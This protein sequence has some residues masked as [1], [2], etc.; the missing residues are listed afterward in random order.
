MV[1][2]NLQFVTFFFQKEA[3]E[4]KIKQTANDVSSRPRIDG[5][6]SRCFFDLNVQLGLA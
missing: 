6:T 1:A 3:E 4:M 2:I 5:S